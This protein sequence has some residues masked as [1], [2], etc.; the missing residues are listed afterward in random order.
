MQQGHRLSQFTLNRAGGPSGRKERIGQ[1]SK[2]CQALLRRAMWCW[3]E[4]SRQV[5]SKDYLRGEE[6]AEPE[7]ASTGEEENISI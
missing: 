4:L 3:R 7:I 5:E 6:A 1:W 2:L